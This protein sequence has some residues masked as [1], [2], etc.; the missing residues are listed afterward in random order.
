[1]LGH[2]DRGAAILAAE[3]QALEQPQRDQ[4]DRRG[5]AD[6]V[7]A[8]QAADEERRQSHDQDGDEEGVLAADQVAET[9][10]EQRAER[11]DQ[12]A[13]GKRKQCENVACGFV[14]RREELR[15]DHSGESAVEIE[16]V[17]LEDGP[18]G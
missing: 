3:R 11:T 12:E 9:A 14:E 8:G 2:V 10:E 15:A 18:R 6:R 4:E 5:H 7:V 13:G 1:M 17:P 16:I